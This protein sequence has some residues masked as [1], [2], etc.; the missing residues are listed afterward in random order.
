MCK[1]YR[2]Q[3]FDP[4]NS[5]EDPVSAD[6]SIGVPKFNPKLSKLR[7]PKIC[8]LYNTQ[9]KS[10]EASVSVIPIKTEHLSKSQGGSGYSQLVGSLVGTIKDAVVAVC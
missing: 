7:N 10:K 3:L 4:K 2:W 5:H 1:V 9:S 8:H 6:S